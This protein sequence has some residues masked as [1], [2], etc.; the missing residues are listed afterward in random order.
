MK[1]EK[2]A[3]TMS[4]T[5]A[6]NE[7]KLLDKRISKKTMNS[8]FLSIKTGTNLAN[9]DCDAKANMQSLTDLINRRS[10]IKAAL[11]K[12]NGITIVKVGGEE[13]TVAAAIEKKTSIK[14]L[15][16][17]LYVLR[18]QRQAMTRQM[19]I[20]NIEA[21]DRLDRLLESTFGKDL[22]ARATEI[23]E[24][25]DTF[26]TANKTILEDE[27]EI[28]LKIEELDEFIDTFESVVDLVLS[29]INAKTEITI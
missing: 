17:L 2:M 6:L 29:E 3:T 14:Y 25:S 22:K 26:W 27:I 4:A 7:L 23:T 11:M 21:Q 24:I 10:T 8:C 13:M 1:N 20:K 15:N 9:K 19:D 16:D 28:D 5:G 18:E 12:S